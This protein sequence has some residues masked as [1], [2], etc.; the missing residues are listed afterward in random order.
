MSTTRHNP[1]LQFYLRLDGLGRVIPGTGVWRLKQ[2]KTGRWKL[3][4]QTEADTCCGFTTI[5]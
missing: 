4:P 2:P 5:G 3:I 1:R